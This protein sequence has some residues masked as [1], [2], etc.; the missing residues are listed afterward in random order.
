MHKSFW[1]WQCSDRYIIPPTHPPPYPLP[2]FSPF[3]INLMVSV[4]VKHHAYCLRICQLTDNC[5]L[6][7]N[8]STLVRG[9]SEWDAKTTNKSIE[10]ETLQP[11]CFLFRTGL[12]KDFHQNAY[13]WKQMGYRT[14]N[15]TVCRC[16]R[17]S[18]SPEVLQ[19][20]SVKGGNVVRC[21]AIAPWQRFNSWLNMLM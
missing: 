15:Y 3:L 5:S 12:W 9:N 21:R 17:E 11:F 2:P 6:C 19:A 1:W 14:G 18:F 8:S 20:G 4:D 7:S 10:F 16:V 13:H